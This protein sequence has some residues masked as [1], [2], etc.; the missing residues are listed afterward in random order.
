MTTENNNCKDCKKRYPACQ[1]TCPDKSKGN[2]FK[3]DAHDKE[4]YNYKAVRYAN[5]IKKRSH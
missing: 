3:K 1:D 2:W 4:Y 5:K